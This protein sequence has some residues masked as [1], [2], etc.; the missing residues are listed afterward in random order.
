MLDSLMQLL[1]ETPDVKV[2]DVGASNLGELPPYQPLLHRGRGELV[3]FEPDS[4]QLAKLQAVPIPRQLFLGDALGDGQEAT[5]HI[6]KIPGMTSLLEPDPEVL[7]H[8][9]GFAE[10]AEVLRKE[11]LQTRRLDD[12]PEVAAATT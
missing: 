3:G 4:D 11:P 8:F 2:V 10:W 7:P 12:V 1:P 9:H 6:C 5:L